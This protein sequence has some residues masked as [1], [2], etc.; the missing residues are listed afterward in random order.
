MKYKKRQHKFCKPCE[1]SYRA[2][3]PEHAVLILQHFRSVFY[4]TL[5]SATAHAYFD[6]ES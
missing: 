2:Y 6:C 5:L 1:I 4:N 3:R